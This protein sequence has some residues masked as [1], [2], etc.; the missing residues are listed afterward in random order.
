MRPS[1]QKNFHASAPS[2]DQLQETMRVHDIYEQLRLADVFGNRSDPE[3]GTPAHTN[4][5]PPEAVDDVNGDLGEHTPLVTYLAVYDLEELAMPQKL[6]STG[7]N[8]P[9]F[10]YFGSCDPE[11]AAFYDRALYRFYKRVL[12]ILRN[13][14]E[15]PLIEENAEFFRVAQGAPLRLEYAM[16]GGWPTALSGVQNGR[17][18]LVT[19]LVLD[20]STKLIMSVHLALLHVSRALR[21]LCVWQELIMC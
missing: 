18:P 13:A 17:F 7:I 16:Y 3:A 9:P 11:E 8:A 6:P 20:Y 15:D 2:Q 19:F 12:K 5:D 21:L 10:E 1:S 14:L 4:A